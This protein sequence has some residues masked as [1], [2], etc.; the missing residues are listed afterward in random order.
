MYKILFF[1]FLAYLFCILIEKNPL[2]IDL[3]NVSSMGIFSP[4]IIRQNVII[5]KTR[6]IL[7]QCI[8]LLRLKIR[9]A[10]QFQPDPGKDQC[11]SDIIENKHPLSFIVA[12]LAKAFVLKET[13]LIVIFWIRER[14]QV[15]LL[16]FQWHP[17]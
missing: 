2:I 8:Y 13:P 3:S 11:C 6:N 15:F 17:S 16:F 7:I 12:I 4:Y 9:H 1:Q 5:G 10:G 14:H